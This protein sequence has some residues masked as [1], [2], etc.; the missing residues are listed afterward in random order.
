MKLS[1]NIEFL[2]ERHLRMLYLKEIGTLDFI[3][4]KYYENV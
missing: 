3:M 1:K 2:T 4:Q